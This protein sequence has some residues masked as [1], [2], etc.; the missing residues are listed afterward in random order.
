MCFGWCEFCQVGIT[1]EETG[2]LPPDQVGARALCEGTT[3]VGAEAR[4]G[5]LQVCVTSKP[6]RILKISNT[7]FRRDNVILKVRKRLS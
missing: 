2:D 5:G 1:S 7:C 6:L 3:K 4:G